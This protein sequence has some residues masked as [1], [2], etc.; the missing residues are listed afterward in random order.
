MREFIDVGSIAEAREALAEAVA[1]MAGPEASTRV[2]AI[3]RGTPEAVILPLPLFEQLADAIDQVR[4]EGLAAQRL[5]LDPGAADENFDQFCRE[6][7]IDPVA[8]AAREREQEL[9]GFDPVE[10]DVP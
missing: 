4:L 2:V 3:G 5:E 7:G 10:V 6:M 8:V 9:T 1:S